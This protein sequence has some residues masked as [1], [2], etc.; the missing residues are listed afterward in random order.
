M[1]HGPFWA[2]QHQFGAYLYQH[3]A[4]GGATASGTQAG[5]GAAAIELGQ[6]LLGHGLL[7]GLATPAG[8]R[9]ASRPTGGRF[10]AA[11][12]SNTAWALAKLQVAEPSAF[13]AL[14]QSA[15]GQ[16]AHFNPQE[17]SNTMWAHAAAIVTGWGRGAPG[18]GQGV[19]DAHRLNESLCPGLVLCRAGRWIVSR[20]RPLSAFLRQHLLVA[21]YTYRSV[22]E[23]GALAPLA[24]AARPVPR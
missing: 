9:K 6:H 3:G 11:E 15:L 2:L 21:M 8:A 16:A 13:D 17:L 14:S 24:T 7:V 4:R 5:R 20:A 23:N 22:G 12:V 10:R 1:W 18:S 19:R